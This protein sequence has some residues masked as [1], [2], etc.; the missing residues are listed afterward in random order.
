MNKTLFP[1]AISLL[2]AM[3]MGLANVSAAERINVRPKPEDH[4]TKKPVRELQEDFRKL[5]FGMFI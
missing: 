5:K 1:S 4:V 3:A 2:I